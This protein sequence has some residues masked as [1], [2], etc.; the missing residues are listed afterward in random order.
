MVRHNKNFNYLGI[1]NNKFLANIFSL[2]TAICQV[3]KI[4][5][6]LLRPGLQVKGVFFSKE[7]MSLRKKWMK[8]MKYEEGMVKLLDVFFFFILR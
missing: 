6:H 4:S 8:C 7:L 5:R 1:Q 2:R 3:M